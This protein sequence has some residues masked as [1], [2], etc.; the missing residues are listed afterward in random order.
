MKQFGDGVE[1]QRKTFT[2][3]IS[4][5]AEEDGQKIRNF[6]RKVSQRKNLGILMTEKKND[7]KEVNYITKQARTKA[8]KHAASIRDFQGSRQY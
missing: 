3:A 5:V 8:E 7:R 2:D 6:Q 1:D 4:A